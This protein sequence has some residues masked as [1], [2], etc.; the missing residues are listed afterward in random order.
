[1]GQ[2]KS[3]SL[4]FRGQRIEVKDL[5]TGPLPPETQQHEA[6]AASFSYSS[7]EVGPED[8]E[9][10]CIVCMNQKR[11]ARLRPCGHTLTCRE[12]TERLEQAAGVPRCPICRIAIQGVRH[13]DTRNRAE[14]LE[15]EGIGAFELAACGAGPAELLGAGFSVEK[16]R[17]ANFTAARL[18]AEGGLKAAELRS[19]GFEA[20]ELYEQAYFNTRALRAAGFTGLELRQ[21]ALAGFFGFSAGELRVAGY[22]LEE[23]VAADYPARFLQASWDIEQ[24]RA[25]NA[26]GWKDLPA[27]RPILIPGRRSLA[28]QDC[29]K[30]R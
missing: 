12:C 5:L 28:A 29:Q 19:A 18:K 6:S 25:A 2:A 3:T 10:L 30:G 7:E 9:E 27:A 22:S 14:E 21:A 1:M 23:L 16:L 13:P 11:T 8:V 15:A 17:N 4:V 20:R 24:L 26:R